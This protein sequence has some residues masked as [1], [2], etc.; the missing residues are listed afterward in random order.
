MHFRPRSYVLL[1]A[2]IVAGVVYNAPAAQACG[3]HSSQ[4]LALGMLNW[5]FPDALH[6]RTAVWQAENSGVLPTRKAQQVRDLFA[7]HKTV[8]QLQGL[9]ARLSRARGDTDPASFTAILLDSMLWVRFAV[10]VDGYAVRPHVNG[11]E[12]GDVVIVTDGKV[13]RALAEGSLGAD[14]AEAH[15]LFRLYRQPERHDR[16]RRVLMNASS[17]PGPEGSME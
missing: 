16:V 6:V 1:I 10:T 7:Y 11:P 4:A 2:L 8:T 5:A 14:Q 15:G 3:Y 12:V 17:A 9:G 13:I